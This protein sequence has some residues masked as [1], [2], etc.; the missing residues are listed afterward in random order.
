MKTE[1]S[2]NNCKH[3]S[4]SIN[5]ASN[6]NAEKKPTPTKEEKRNATIKL[7]ISCALL[8]IFTVIFLIIINKYFAEATTISE[9]MENHRVIGAVILMLACIIQVTF[10]VIPGELIEIAFGYAF[11]A[12]LGTVLCL[13][14]I[15]IGSVL[16][17]IIIR[18]MNRSFLSVLFPTDKRDSLKFFRNPTKRN[19]LV[20][21]LFFIPGTPKDLF[22]YVIALTDMR[23]STYILI[24]SI[25]RIPT[26]ISSTIGGG[27]L[28]EQDYT[29]AIWAFA[30]T[31]FVSLIGIIAYQIIIK[32]H[33]KKDNSGK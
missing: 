3:D 33:E 5:K 18:K 12:V 31:G 8:I 27:A 13:I 1:I 2:A 11:G 4:E 9:F 15:M 6:I 20:A 32:H 21:L 10:A 19:F 26:I 16:T 22:T 30:I 24:T 23:I 29:F 28:W 17:I 25:A 14:G 7:L